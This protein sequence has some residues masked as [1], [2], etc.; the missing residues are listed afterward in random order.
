MERQAKNL[1]FSA[2]IL[3]FTTYIQI[4]AIDKSKMYTFSRLKK[5]FSTY[6]INIYYKIHSF[7]KEDIE[8][9]L[10][11]EFNIFKLTY[12]HLISF[13]EVEI[14]NTFFLFA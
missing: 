3:H 7:V 8:R 5:L 11:Q 4:C 2:T 14:Q 1:H 6:N 13:V 12:S 9:F 10:C